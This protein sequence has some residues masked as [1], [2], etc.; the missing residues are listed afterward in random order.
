MKIACVAGSFRLDAL[1][2]RRGSRAALFAGQP[3]RRVALA[4]GVAQAALLA[5]DIVARHRHHALPLGE[6]DLEHHQVLLAERH[7]R[8]RQ[9]EL[10]HAHKAPVVNA[11]D[12]LA[13]GEEALAPGLQR[14]GVMQAQ[15]LDVG[16]QQAGLLDAGST[17]DSDGM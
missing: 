2:G 5:R 14:L 17:S 1:H 4:F 10:P 12:L 16:D 7:F 15:D 6:L 13:V 9:I 3:Q 8:R 11:L